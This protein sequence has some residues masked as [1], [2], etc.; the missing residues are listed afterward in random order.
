MTATFSDI[1]V[2]ILLVFAFQAAAFL[3]SCWFGRDFKPYNTS[4]KSSRGSVATISGHE[5]LQVSTVVCSK[6]PEIE[7]CSRDLP[8]TSPSITQSDPIGVKTPAHLSAVQQARLNKACRLAARQDGCN[9]KG[10]RH[11]GRRGGRETRRARRAA[12]S[13]VQA[14]A[15]AWAA[16]VGVQPAVQ[17]MGATAANQTTKQPSENLKQ[18]PLDAAAPVF[19]PKLSRYSCYSRAV[20][21]GLAD[22]PLC[23]SSV[24]SHRT[25]VAWVM[26]AQVHAT[27]LVPRAAGCPTRLSA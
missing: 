17:S 25:H 12:D 16:R 19:V 10:R 7:S 22:P 13:S 1:V 26:C 27:C 6:T 4:T 8:Q 20:R 5:S 24:V 15:A 23:V 11:H 18:T 3:W 21:M 2:S 14:R 9:C